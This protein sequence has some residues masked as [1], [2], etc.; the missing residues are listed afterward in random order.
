MSYGLYKPGQGYWTRVMTAVGAGMIALAAAVWLW[1]Q[2]GAIRI[3]KFDVI[4]LQAGAASVIIVIAT[5]LI[6]W[7]V[8]L[9]HK[10]VEF[11]IATEGEMQ[12]VNWSS[13]REV[14]GST[15]VV[16]GVSLTIAAVL[17]ITDLAFAKFFQV[18]N[19]LQTSP[20]GS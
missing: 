7:L 1:P 15:Y 11:F 6:Y 19:V 16:I 8:G 13:R 10:A 9:S 14:I 2:L 17:F 20:V 3:Q 12:K 18:I 4:Y 5:A